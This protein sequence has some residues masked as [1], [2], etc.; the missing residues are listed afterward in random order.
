MKITMLI[1]AEA[2]MLGVF[3]VIFS[4]LQLKALSPNAAFD[5]YK[6]F[7]YNVQMFLL[8]VCVALPISIAIN[9]FIVKIFVKPISRISTVLKDY[10]DE[11]SEKRS[12]SYKRLEAAAVNSNDEVE[13]LY[14]SVKHLIFDMCGYI[15][16]LQREKA[17]EEEVN[18]QT[19]RN[20]LLTREFMTALAGTVDAKDHYTKGHSERVAKYSREIAKRSGKS[21]YEQDDIY[22]MGLLHD[23]GKIGVSEAIINKTSRLTDE[24]YAQIKKHPEIG[25]EI[26]KNV[27]AMPGLATG[28]RWHHERYDGKGYPDG[29]SGVNIPEEARIIAVADAYD[30][31]TSN[32]AYSTVR[33]QAEVRAEILKCKG[34]QFDPMFA[35]IML[36]MIDDD[37]EYV[38][39][40]NYGL[41]KDV[42]FRIAD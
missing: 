35:D 30:A 26:L 18:K 19:K 7:I 24:E 20:E 15:D 4:N 12:K 37:K 38:M 29:L 14:D 3:A 16:T 6:L 32:R 8:I 25:Y 21:D 5:T 1:M 9:E 39:N 41:K 42:T 22:I 34:T 2:F 13:Q 33:P 36:Q 11:D 27:T 17:L 40:E 31:M 28:A 23:I 10:F